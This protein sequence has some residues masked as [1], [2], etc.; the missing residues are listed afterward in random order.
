MVTVYSVRSGDGVHAIVMQFVEGATLRTLM[1]EVVDDGTG[2]A[3]NV[4]GLDVAGKTGTA[5]RKST[6]LNSSHT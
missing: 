1:K 2:T 5:D 4:A 6:R 3:A